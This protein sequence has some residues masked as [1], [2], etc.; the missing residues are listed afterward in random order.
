MN[1]NTFINA[2][3]EKYYRYA[4]SLA[5]ITVAYNFIEGLVSIYFGYEDEVLTLFGFGIDS[6][7]E[8]ISALGILQMIRRIKNN[9]TTEKSVFEVR[10]LKIT[11][12]CFYS[13]SV[14]LAIGAGI[15][16]IEN[17]KPE[18]T[19]AGIIIASISIFT[20]WLLIYLK[21]DLGRKLNSDAIIADANCNLVCMYMSF[22]LLAS[23]LFYK[24]T[25]FGWLDALGAM[26]IIWFSIKE[27]KEAFE[28]AKGNAC[29]CCD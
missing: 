8:T 17:R 10:A 24:M 5:I 21:K 23:S 26:G 20:M 9:S 15:S 1:L 16:L 18:T 28:K 4:Y 11:G 25:G 6:F 19:F 7:V 27:G 3:S 22:V 29:I 2:D 12:W 13:L 14:L